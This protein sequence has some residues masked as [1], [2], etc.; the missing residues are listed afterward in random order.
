VVIQLERQGAETRYQ[1]IARHANEDVRKQHE[2]KGFQQG[3]SQCLDPLVV[4]MKNVP[5]W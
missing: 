4:L 2:A 5:A 3:S 1:A